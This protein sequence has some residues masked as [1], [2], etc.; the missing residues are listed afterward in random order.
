MSDVRVQFRHLSGWMKFI[1]IW[2][3]ISVG[4]SILAFIIGLIIGIS[5][6]IV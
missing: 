2:G 4:Y 1:V 6:P 5:E 3:F